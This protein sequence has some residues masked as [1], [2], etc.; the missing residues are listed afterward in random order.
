MRPCYQTGLWLL[1]AGLLPLTGCVTLKDA[2]LQT[3]TT[4][5][6]P[7]TP[8][9]PAPL[10][11]FHDGETEKLCLTMAAKF[12]ERGYWGDEI[13]MLEKAR[14]ANPHLDLSDR[15]ADLYE[16]EA[17]YP[18]AMAEY[19]KEL[20]KARQDDAA[21]LNNI[22][23]RLKKLLG[24]PLPKSSEPCVLTSIGYCLYMKGDWGE[25]ERYLKQ[26]VEKDPENQKAW[27]NLGLTLAA[28]YRVEDSL[29]ALQ[30]VVSPAAA[31]ANAAFVL[32]T[33][34]D[35]VAEAKVLYHKALEL[36]PH[37]EQAHRA[38]TELEQIEK[39]EAA[40]SPAPPGQP[41]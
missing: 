11:A 4:P 22:L 19:N 29:N 14:Q 35:R 1:L 25:S 21:V 40:N 16:K 17:D 12:D 3:P 36:D 34:L 39:K 15:L 10:T 13:Q 9:A 8:V 7:G 32:A 23:A 31:Y 37:N 28:Q 24:Q 20:E 6:A 5:S 33:R 18:R 38:L 41:G 26:A 30:H 2:T 27:V